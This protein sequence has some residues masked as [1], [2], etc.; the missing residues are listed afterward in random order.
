MDMV[1]RMVGRTLVVGGTGTS[2]D[3]SKIVKTMSEGLGLTIPR[4][5]ARLG[6]LRQLQLLRGRDS[7]AVPVHGACTTTTTARRTTPR[8]WTSTARA[9]TGRLALRMLS[10]VDALDERLRLPTPAPGMAYDFKPHVYFGV[11]FE[12][13]APPSPAG[14]RAA[15]V[16]PTRPAALAGLREGDVVTACKRPGNH[17]GLRAARRC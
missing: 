3:L 17:Q 6:A 12:D 5:P 14:A 4:R 9:T 10:A 13:S 7:G 8:S 15:V 2:L 1:G 16:V 11:A